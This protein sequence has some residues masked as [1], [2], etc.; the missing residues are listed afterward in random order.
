MKL[1]FIFM[2]LFS[3]LALSAPYS[4]AGKVEDMLI[5]DSLDA[6][7]IIYVK[8][9]STAGDCPKY[10]SN[11]LV[12]LSVKNDERAKS[13]FSMALSAH[14]ADRPIKIVV[15]DRYIDANGNCLIK[16]IRFNSSF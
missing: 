12:I 4:R 11:N 7:A 15:D 6:F 9:F 5:R 14:M 3:S 2:M 8:G 10:E 13:I 16:D 1:V